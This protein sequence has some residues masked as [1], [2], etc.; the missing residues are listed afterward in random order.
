[1]LAVVVVNM[2]YLMCYAYM[3]FVEAGKHYRAAEELLKAVE[4]PRDV[5]TY[6]HNL[7][8]STFSALLGVLV[9]AMALIALVLVLVL[10]L[11]D[12]VG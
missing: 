9:L 12:E 6:V 2:A 10:K 3:S 8:M 1:M 7:V 11:L 4:S 5:A